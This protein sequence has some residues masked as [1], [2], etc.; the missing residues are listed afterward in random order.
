MPEFALHVARQ[1]Q[2]PRLLLVRYAALVEKAGD[3]LGILA[4]KVQ[5]NA[6]VPI[7]AAIEHGADEARLELCEEPQCFSGAFAQTT[8]APRLIFRVEQA[9]VFAQRFVD[10]GILRQRRIDVDAEARGG[11]ALGDMESRGCRPR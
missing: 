4:E 9:L 8:Q 7:G 2:R 5:A 3:G 11:L 6:G 10:F 1:P